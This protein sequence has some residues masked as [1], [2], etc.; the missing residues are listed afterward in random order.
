MERRL[1]TTQENL[2]AL[3]G[4]LDPAQAEILGELPGR[5]GRMTPLC[6]LLIYKVGCLLRAEAVTRHSA[7]CL[8][9]GVVAGLIGATCR[10]SL[11]TD[12]AFMNSMNQGPGLASPALFGYTLPNSP[13]AEAATH[14]GLVGPVYAIFETENPLERSRQEAQLLLAES[15]DLHM[16]ICCAFDHYTKK[17]GSE[18][19]AANL[20]LLRKNA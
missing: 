2:W 1:Q 17:D 6:R 20:Q 12:L 5:W 15:A 7:T 18:I 8:Q 4:R 19:L 11:H 9:G 3:T 13:L 14:Y 10:G 16:M